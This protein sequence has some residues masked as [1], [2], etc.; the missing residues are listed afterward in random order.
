MLAFSWLDDVD[1]RYAK[2]CGANLTTAI[3]VGARFDEAD[4]SGANLKSA[5]IKSEQLGKAKSL[6]GCIMP[7]GTLYDSQKPLDEQ[8]KP[9]IEK[10]ST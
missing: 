3:L 9:L 2:L 1:L 5:I 6:E 4:L 7:S 10:E 8:C